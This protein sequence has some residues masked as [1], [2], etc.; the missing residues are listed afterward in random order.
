MIALA[1][2]GELSGPVVGRA[3]QSFVTLDEPTCYVR[4]RPQE[5]L[6]R[7]RSH[8]EALRFRHTRDGTVRAIKGT[9]L[10]PADCFAN[11]DIE[12]AARCW[13][14]EHA[15]LYGVSAK[16]DVEVAVHKPGPGM[17]GLV[18]VVAVQTVSGTRVRGT[19]LSFSL[20]DGHLVSVIGRL[21]DVAEHDGCENAGR[22]LDAELDLATGACVV[23]R[24]DDSG[25]EVTYDVSTGRAMHRRPMQQNS[26]QIMGCGIEEHMKQTW[27]NAL[28][29]CDAS[30]NPI[31]LDTLPVA[32]LPSG[33][34]Q[35]IHRL[36]QPGRGPKSVSTADN[37]GAPVS[38]IADC[39]DEPF[40][41]LAFDPA[42]D[43]ISWA[44]AVYLFYSRLEG[45]RDAY[46]WGM[47]GYPGANPSATWRIEQNPNFS[48]VTAGFDSTTNESKINFKTLYRS[49][50]TMIH[51]W[52]HVT[53][54]A[55][56]TSLTLPAWCP[57]FGESLAEEMKNRWLAYQAVLGNAPP[58][59]IESGM[60]IIDGEYRY[61]AS[62]LSHYP[63]DACDGTGVYHCNGSSQICFRSLSKIM[64]SLR[65][66]VCGE[67]YGSCPSP[68]TP[69]VADPTAPEAIY[70]AEY[71]DHAL[72]YAMS[73]VDQ[74]FID[75]RQPPPYPFTR[76][77]DA[78]YH[79]FLEQM[80][81]FYA[82]NTQITVG[83]MNRLHAVFDRIGFIDTGTHCDLANSFR[84]PGSRLPAA[85][86]YKS[87][88][89]IEAESGA[90]VG[91]LLKEEAWQNGASSDAYV[92][93][94][95]VSTLADRVVVDIAN[96]PP[97]SYYVRLLAQTGL[98]STMEVDVNGSS[99][100]VQIP[101]GTE[102]AWHDLTSPLYF[103][104]EGTLELFRT[105]GG[106]TSVDVV[107]LEPAG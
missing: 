62:S 91:T 4:D 26:E 2:L 22:D 18:V 19:Q 68:S 51:E 21:R 102:W 87:D 53:E 55:Y 33:V 57:L 101:V 29:T 86:T 31:V 106:A 24:P 80:V 107:L 72:A 63:V 43:H 99:A 48:G 82:L 90:L 104:G 46:L 8:D 56:R 50:S 95:S 85:C 71:A 1:L 10:D 3:P 13:A 64:N 49:S 70:A 5:A 45:F 67:P 92:N 79:M 40:A 69:I 76:K 77:E 60:E 103:G 73:T 17:S 39:G 15:D 30:F 11:S 34:A 59:A 98:M 7:L 52:G 12:R 16:A 32:L 47:N 93:F 81:E 96:V 25:F 75:D 35:C 28:P 27:T 14:R 94:W 100:S 36:E 105:A 42:S 88:L 84:L 58:K 6:A 37:G 9:D 83:D 44:A 74:T 65:N 38:I 78:T 23:V 61:V 20:K 89:F 54:D 66:N 97:G 41:N